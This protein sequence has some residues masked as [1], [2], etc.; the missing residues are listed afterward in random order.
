M[1]KDENIA[2]PCS[3]GCTKGKSIWRSPHGQGLLGDSD[4]FLTGSSSEEWAPRLR[5]ARQPEVFSDAAEVV[6]VW[7]VNVSMNLFNTQIQHCGQMKAML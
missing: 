3:N 4:G 6:S 7:L 2:S 5:H 1:P